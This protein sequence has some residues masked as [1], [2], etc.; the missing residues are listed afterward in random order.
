LESGVPVNVLSVVNAPDSSAPAVAT[1]A[2]TKSTHAD[3]VR[4][5][6]AAQR[7]AKASGDRNVMAPLLGLKCRAEPVTRADTLGRPVV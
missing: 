7:R 2:I 6:R 3:T 4:H 5:G 1:E